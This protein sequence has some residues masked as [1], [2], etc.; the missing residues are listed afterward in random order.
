M[1]WDEDSEAWVPGAR[2]APAGIRPGL[3]AIA[4]KRRGD[5]EGVRRHARAALEADR[6]A[7]SEHAAGRVAKR[8]NV[9]GNAWGWWYGEI[10]GRPNGT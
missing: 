8:S 9:T 1:G 4:A 7:I 10:T 2:L 6:Y 5:V 3:A